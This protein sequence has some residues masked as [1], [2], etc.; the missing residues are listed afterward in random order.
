MAN[1][2]FI[3]EAKIISFVKKTM[4]ENCEPSENDIN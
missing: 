3:I 1:T 4:R 2:K